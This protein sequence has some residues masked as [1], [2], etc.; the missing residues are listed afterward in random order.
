MYAFGSGVSQ[1]DAEAVAWYRLAAEQG[2]ATAQYFLGVSY[3][4]GDG[5]P[6]DHAEAV[7]WHRKA[8]EQGF[9]SSQYFLGVMYDNGD[10]VPQD[11]AE[12]VTWY[13]PRRG[14]ERR[15][16]AVQP[17]ADVRQWPWRPTR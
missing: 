7:T 14:A 3:D 9:D 13:P 6:Q 1:D 5:V 10:G 15:R 16:G 8:A 12:A 11:D 2:H 17:R 4:N